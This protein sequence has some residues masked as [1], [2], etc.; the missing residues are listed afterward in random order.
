M[1]GGRTVGVLGASGAVGGAAVRE[2]R[3]LGYSA[4]LLGGRRPD[5][6]REVAR[7]D[8]ETVRVDVADPDGLAAFAGRCDVVL[9]CAGPTYRL[10][11]TVAAAADSAG[12][13]CVDVA[14]DDPAA[15]ALRA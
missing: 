14:G 11:A 10:K 13:H 5:A 3:D 15:E 7:G 6:L 9:N 4:L 12:P 2:L 1:T 8:D